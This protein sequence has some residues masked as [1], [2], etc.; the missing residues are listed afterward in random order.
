VFFVCSLRFESVRGREELVRLVGFEVVVLVFSLKLL[1]VVFV[2]FLMALVGSMQLGES[3]SSSNSSSNSNI[4]QR[5]A[6]C[7]GE[8]TKLMKL[9][10][11][12]TYV[13]D[14]YSRRRYRETVVCF[15]SSGVKTGWCF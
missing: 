2:R 10:H 7:S 12:A 4:S 9:E 15:T 13:K 6:L 1:F 5:M 11:S 14:I 8:Y 3:E